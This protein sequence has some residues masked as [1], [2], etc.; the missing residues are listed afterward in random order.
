MVSRLRPTDEQHAA[1]TAFASGEDL[2]IV[3]GA[4][5]GKTSTLR[6]LADATSRRGLYLA[7]NKAI[8]EEAKTVF[9]RSVQARTAHSL[10][11]QWAARAGY[12]PVLA[13]L[14]RP[15]RHPQELVEALGVTSMRIPTT[16]G[17]VT[18]GDRHVLRWVNDVLGS[19]LQSADD[20]IDPTRHLPFIPGAT[21]QV[22]QDVAAA[23]APAV[24]TAWEDL[25]SEEGVMPMTHAVYLKLWG[26]SRPALPADVVL[27]DEAQDASPVVA[28]V[29]TDQPM[30]KVMVG[31]PAQSIYRFT[32]AVDAMSGFHAPHRLTLTRSWRFGPAIAQAANTYLGLLEHDLR[33]VG[34]P[35]RESRVLDLAAGAQALLCRGN[36]T[37]IGEA[38]YAQQ[39][40]RRVHILGGTD[41][42]R[43]FVEAAEQLQDTGRSTH[44]ELAMFSS[45]DAVREYA[46][47]DS[48]PVELRTL[49]GLVDRFGTATL[50]QVLTACV[51]EES[52]ADVVISTVHKAKGREW[53]RVDL[54][55]DLDPTP[56][57]ETLTKLS[58]GGVVDGAAGLL[59]VEV[60]KA[61][62]E[63]MI[64]YVAATRA[65]TDLG[66][67][68]LAP[69]LA[70]HGFPP[71]TTRPPAADTAGAASTGSCGG[72]GEQPRIIAGSGHFELVSVPV[73]RDAWQALRARL[74]DC[75]ALIWATDVLTAAL[76]TLDLTGPALVDEPAHPDQQVDVTA[77][78]VLERVV[79]ADGEPAYA[80]VAD[81]L[82]G[83]SAADQVRTWI[84]Q[85]VDAVR[86]DLDGR[87][88][89]FVDEQL[90][91]QVLDRLP[92]DGLV[93]HRSRGRIGYSL[94]TTLTGQPIRLSAANFGVGFSGP[95]IV[96]RLRHPVVQ[97]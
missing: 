76:H 60:A 56:A 57:L 83:C 14:G 59:E 9:P 12:R 37:T 97:P 6:M 89:G 86:H 74:G 95:A 31:D 26:L 68:A 80:K 66:A 54:A 53:D 50:H 3:A 27:Y 93:V 62:E 63:L 11:Y 51:T 91:A 64:G 40:G 88:S 39:A 69:A 85:A 5:T 96:R 32:G 90:L 7:F 30:Q 19:F 94:T 36:A 67:G 78:R 45:W 58:T 43:R 1:V 2:V 4:G 41:A 44:P 20:D 82:L 15:R 35:G 52:A 8:A 33:L 34:N 48:A 79:E 13:R 25:C 81:E 21:P 22:L 17:E 92:R 24:A 47:D 77:A 29:V 65:R 61:R 46:Q 38:A 42:A 49:V 10:A 87:V 55:E 75:D 73:D 84:D 23:L 18:F 70:R 16:A 72:R 28:A 71:L